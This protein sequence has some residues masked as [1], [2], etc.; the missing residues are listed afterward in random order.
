MSSWGWKRFHNE[1]NQALARHTAV[2]CR[3]LSDWASVD[4]ISWPYHN[5]LHTVGR[6]GGSPWQASICSGCTVLLPIQPL[7]QCFELQVVVQQRDVS[8]LLSVLKASLCRDAAADWGLQCMRYEIRD[9]SPP[10]GVR[11][12]MEL[13]VRMQ[14]LS[15]CFVAHKYQ[16]LNL[17]LS[18]AVWARATWR[19]TAHRIAAMLWSLLPFS[20]Y[21]PGW[22][23]GCSF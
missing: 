11:A 15:S 5:S 1:L 9:I 14:Y 2:R 7:L 3:S 6:A 16:S 10:T 13:Q 21:C 19:F 17:F 18:M 22:H 4:C 20:L 8:Y 23:L 12:A